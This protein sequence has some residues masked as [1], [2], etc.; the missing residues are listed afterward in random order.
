MPKLEFP[1]LP[2]RGILVFPYMLIHLDVGRERSMAAIEDAMLKDKQVLLLA[3]KEIEIDNPT[4]DDLYTVGTIVEIKQLLRLPGGTLRVLVEGITRGQV[5]EFIEEEPFF[6]ARVIRMTNDD[7]LT[8]EIET[9]CRS[10]HHQFEEYARLSKRISPETI[11]SVLAVKEPGRMADL[12]A[13]HL[14]LKIEDKQAVLEAMNISDRLE[15]ITELIMREIEILELERRIGLR[16]RKQMEKAQKEY[17]LREQ[18]KAIQKELGDKDEKQA[19][20]EEYKEKVNKGNLTEE[21]REKALKEIDRLDKMP[22]SSSEGTVVRTYLDWILALPWNKTSRDKADLIRAERILDEDHYGLKKVKERIIE[23]LS[24]RKLTSK[25]KSPIL[26][27]VGPPGVGKTSLAKSI[28][29]ALDRKFVRMSLGGVRDEAEIRGHRRTYI[30]ALPGRVIQGIRQAGTRNP[31]FLFDEIDKMTSDLR[32]DPAS[33]LLEVL[34]PEQNNTFT[35]HYLELP[36]DLSKVLFIMTANS[37]DTIPRPLLDRMEVIQLSGY[38]EEEKVNIAVEHL[39]NKQMK[40]HGLKDNQVSIDPSAVRKIVRGY[41]RESG[42]RNMERQIA[43]LLRKVAVKVVKNEW[44]PQTIMPEDVEKLLG[45]S[46]FQHQAAAHKPEIGA[47]TGLAYTEV[48]GE[49]LMIEV[50]PLVGKGVLTLT[51]KLGDIMKESAQAG[52]TFVRSHASELGIRDDFYDKIDLHIHVPEGAVPKDGPSAG[53]TMATA[54]ASALAKRAVRQDVAMTGEITLRGNVL[55]IGG[56]KEKALAA[57]RA[58][59]K[60]VIVPKDNR[61]DLE[62]IPQEVRK[63]L[64]FILVERMEEVLN[65]ALLPVSESVQ[66]LRDVPVY[67]E[68]SELEMVDEAGNHNPQERPL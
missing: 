21:A 42:V 45:A 7:N 43:N 1:V 51:G 52:W 3:Q 23:F 18:M 48:G 65:V 27:L 60:K 56:L 54:M 63:E 5:D 29:R 13:S 4:P 19:E 11:G 67:S 58:G 46:R 36:F 50:T 28:A 61:K 24:I 68:F 34:D 57:H 55:P 16:V 53:I 62:E 15:K 59:L 10:L 44:K 33:A 20:I 37:M 41:T 8:R 35:D 14:N 32:G 22:V 49:V 39:V 9:M 26:C 12:V 17:Y 6:K 40:G 38:T 66:Y 31:V 30:G 64:E 2:L 25:M 47:A